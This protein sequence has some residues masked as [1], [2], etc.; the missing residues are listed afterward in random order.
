[1]RCLH[2]WQIVRTIS[3]GSL[4][5]SIQSEKAGRPLPHGCEYRGE[6][7]SLRVCLKCKLVSDEIAEASEKI[8]NRL[9]IEDERMATALSI[10]KEKGIK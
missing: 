4:A 1:M 8:R 10:I 7:L 6:Y 3:Y 5:H 9:R 2:D